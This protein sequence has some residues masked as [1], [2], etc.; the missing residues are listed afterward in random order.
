MDDEF[1]EKTEKLVKEHNKKNKNHEMIEHLS[2]VLTTACKP[3]V[4]FDKNATKVSKDFA[5]KAT[6]SC[7]SAFIIERSENID[8]AMAFIELVKKNII[9]LEKEVNNG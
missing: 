1:F 8:E 3:L 9:S 2:D 5:D 6:A 7:L 4:M